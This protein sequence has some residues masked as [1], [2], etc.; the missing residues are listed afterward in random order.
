[1]ENCENLKPYKVASKFSS[2]PIPNDFFNNGK[3]ELAPLIFKLYDGLLPSVKEYRDFFKVEDVLSFL[4][5]NNAQIVQS[6]QCVR[7]K[8]P[9][10]TEKQLTEN[11]ETE[12]VVE[13]DVLSILDLELNNDEIYYYKDNFIHIR[14]GN[15]MKDK[16]KCKLTFYFP[17]GYT[18]VNN[19][20]NAFLS[21]DGREKP[22][23]YMINQDFGTFD[24]TKF[25]VEMP[26]TFSLEMNY[27][28]DF[29]D[30]SEKIV[31]SLHENYSGL[32]MLHG[33]PGTGK[34]TYI[35]YL[36]SVLKKEVI[37]FPTS[38]ID[39]ITN[40]SIL[41]LMRE[42][43]DCVLI[44]EDAEKALTKR[45]LSDQ[46]SLVSTLLNMTDGILGDILKLNVVVTY[47][48]DR[49]SIDE[50]LLRKGRLKAE[51]SFQGLSKQDAQLL[52]NKLNL[53]LEAKDGMLLADI[54]HAKGDEELISNIKSL[55][56]EAR[57]GF[58]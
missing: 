18:C 43:Q 17:T 24:F 51:Y 57:I 30:I 28:K 27:G 55:K 44:L 42:K 7:L 10:L 23:V 37:F 16:S 20:F 45:N 36:A 3:A 31:K 12:L 46:P 48:C 54:F 53:Q 33:L 6:I 22:N 40:P 38:F 25:K 4:L 35:K 26:K 9:P 29:I 11:C 14:L 15:S 50:A 34:T 19:E 52:I 56:E 41:S 2:Q 8:D 47:N 21:L 13:N 58:A 32:Y 1:M 39:E 5:K 49:Q